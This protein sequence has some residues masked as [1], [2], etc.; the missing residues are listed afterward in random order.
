MPLT[1]QIFWKLP[2]LNLI[3][4]IELFF[5]GN[6]SDDCSSQLFSSTNK[7]QSLEDRKY[8][9]MKKFFLQF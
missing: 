8:F 4:K 7:M 5:A 3:H 2:A 1:Q 6:E 9:L